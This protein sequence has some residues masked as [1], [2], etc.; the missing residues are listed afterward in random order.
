MTKRV[1]AKDLIEAQEKKS[2]EKT[3]AEHWREFVEM[4]VVEKLIIMLI[5]IPILLTCVSIGL[6]IGFGLLGCL[7]YGIIFLGHD[8]L[9]WEMV[10]DW[11]HVWRGTLALWLSMLLIR[12]IGRNFR[13]PAK[14]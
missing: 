2:E 10:P 13:G 11:Y 7:T 12:L 1:T 4:N 9:D 6:C 14:K 8:L 5:V 3:W